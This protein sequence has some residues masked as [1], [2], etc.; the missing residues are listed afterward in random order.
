MRAR[1]MAVDV[2]HG[3]AI[4]SDEYGDVVVDCIYYSEDKHPGHVLIRGVA[5]RTRKDAVVVLKSC[6][7]VE[8]CLPQMVECGQ[9]SK[10]DIVFVNG[11]WVCVSGVDIGKSMCNLYAVGCKSK[12]HES[13]GY[14]PISYPLV[15]IRPPWHFTRE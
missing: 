11:Q 10:G 15:T 7:A 8:Y 14:I 1:I 4:Y 5:P 3:M 12:G 2:C 13:I 9:I 6:E